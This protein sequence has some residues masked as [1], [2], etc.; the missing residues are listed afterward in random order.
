[1]GERKAPP[2]YKFRRCKVFV[3]PVNNPS[4]WD[5]K[6]TI[7]V[8]A[9]PGHGACDANHAGAIGHCCRRHPPRRHHCGCTSA[10]GP[11]GRPLR[12]LHAGEGG[13]R[14]P[15]PGRDLRRNHVSTG[16]EIRQ[17]PTFPCVHIQDRLDQVLPG[18]RGQSYRK[19][20]EGYRAVWG[21]VSGF[22][23]NS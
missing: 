12:V 22:G 13:G 1:M 10:N 15:S 11:E 23:V 5:M 20:C 2:K 4:H 18:T 3:Q 9:R 8:G 17:R 7:R 14:A 21:D 16:N 6:R 19:R